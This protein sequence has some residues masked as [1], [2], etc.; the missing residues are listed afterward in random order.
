[1]ARCSQVPGDLGCSWADPCTT[2]S[3]RGLTAEV[4]NPT[5]ISDRQGCNFPVAFRGFH[6]ST[7]PSLCT[8]S[9]NQEHS[10]AEPSP[11]TTC[12]KPSATEQRLGHSQHLP[13]PCL[14]CHPSPPLTAASRFTLLLPA[15]RFYSIKLFLSAHAAQE[16]P[17]SDQG[18]PAM[19]ARGLGQQHPS[20]GSCSQILSSRRQQPSVGYLSALLLTFPV[21][22]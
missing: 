9:M 3:W 2:R 16:P 17:H 12:C 5:E 18:H 6:T 4:L 14:R 8:G 1:M 19:P 21:R 15:L 20:R 7:S 10:P 11:Q 22:M 13:A